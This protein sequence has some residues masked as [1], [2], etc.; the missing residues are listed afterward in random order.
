LIIDRSAP[1]SDITEVKGAILNHKLG[2]NDL[3]SMEYYNECRAWSYRID[4]RGGD[5]EER[6]RS[7]SK[8]ARRRGEKITQWKDAR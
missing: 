1:A 7:E 4:S 8:V 5:D 6:G 3:K 2:D